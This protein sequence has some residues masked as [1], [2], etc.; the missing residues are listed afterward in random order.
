VRAI[1]A[2]YNHTCALM[3]AG[4]VECWG[5]DAYGQLGNGKTTNSGAP[6]AVSG[7][8]GVSAI[9]AG[10]EHTCALSSTGTVKCWGDNFDGELGDGKTEKSD[11]PVAVSGLSGVTAIAA[12]SGNTCAVTSAGTADC[13][14]Y[15]PEGTLGDGKT[16]NSDVPVAVSGLTGASAIAL[17][18]Q[19]CA[20]AS[21]G[22]VYCWGRGEEGALGD[23][24]TENSDVPV[25]VSGL[26]GASAVAGGFN[27]TCALMSA[28]TVE[29]WGDNYAGVLGNESASGPERCYGESCSKTPIEVPDLPHE[30]PATRTPNTPEV[31]P[32][33]EAPHISALKE[34]HT[35]WR[36]AKRAAKISRNHPLGTTFSF[37][38]N[39]A[40]RVSFTFTHKLAGR[41]VA[42]S[43][44]AQTKENRT[45]RA[46]K[47]TVIAG[48]FVFTGHGGT[49]K[50]VFYG[51]LSAHRKLQP[52]SYTLLVTATTAGKTSN[53]QTLHFT[54]LSH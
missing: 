37:S 41:R 26:T 49:N 43:C 15:G 54:I 38:L 3:S 46:C 23:G 19:A 42:R 52:G 16:E 13:W 30:A 14:G 48:T 8:S 25:A 24:N 32:A 47:R 45:H 11:V 10:G 12:G 18:S 44:R 28:G 5:D 21:A 50:L 36:E 6:V 34:S 53:T 33:S 31:A 35:S 9:A 20:V 51:L 17:G 29:C 7:L 27:H 22:A 1:S 4:T 39:E 40:A 2:G